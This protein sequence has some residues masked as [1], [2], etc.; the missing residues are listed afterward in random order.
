[1]I[2]LLREVRRRL[3]VGWLEAIAFAVATL[4]QLRRGQE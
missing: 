1:M 3:G 4:W 2:G